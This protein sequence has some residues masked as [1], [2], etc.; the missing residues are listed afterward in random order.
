MYIYIYIYIYVINKAAD[1]ISALLPDH[2]CNPEL[3]EL[4]QTF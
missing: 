2:F 1:R 3:F 4:V